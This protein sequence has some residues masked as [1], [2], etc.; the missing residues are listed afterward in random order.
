MRPGA[1][2]KA[3]LYSSVAIALVL[4]APR[5]MSAQ[6][7]ILDDGV[8]VDVAKEILKGHC[9]FSSDSENG[10]SRPFYWIYFALLYAAFGNHPAMFFLANAV[11][12]A[13]TAA[14]IAFLSH[15]ATGDAAQ[16]SLAGVLFVLSGPGIESYYTLSKGEPVQLLLVCASLVLA[17]RIVRLKGF[18]RAAHVAAMSLMLF[19]AYATKE[20]TIALIPI[21]FLWFVISLMRG[22]ASNR[23]TTTAASF[24]V[25][26]LIATLGFLAMRTMLGCAALYDGAYTYMYILDG[27]R[28][29]SSLSA[30]S[31][32]T[33][34]DFLYV[35]P[36][37]AGWVAVKA[38]GDKKT[39]EKLLAFALAW[40][41]SWMAV[42]M[43]WIYASEYYML[44]FAAGVTFVASLMAADVGRAMLRSRGIVKASLAGLLVASAAL[45]LPTLL[46]NAKN[47]QIQL[48]VNRV[49]AETL[50]Y[51]AD[52]TPFAGTVLLNTTVQ[53]RIF[54]VK[55][56]LSAI[57]DRPDIQV[58]VLPN[59]AGQDSAARLADY[60]VS[61]RI[62]NRPHL[63]V[64]M[65][66]LDPP[67][68]GTPWRT[69]NEGTHE[70]W[71][72]AASYAGSFSA[73]TFDLPNLM[74]SA[75]AE[76]LCQANEQVIDTSVFSYDVT[77][78]RRR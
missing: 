14:M 13:S 21:A 53:G 48:V 71:E 22:T 73:T 29:A 37:A 56:Y 18:V 63:A 16:A 2:K 8:S 72:A 4:M 76:N 61:Q 74:C 67:Q 55:L 25:A 59:T 43:P 17:T 78:E 11:L 75:F 32:W 45:F 36:L 31:L 77:I 57:E 27:A 60:V 66:M 69:S 34:R 30:W 39:H 65:F 70:S 3:V 58:R 49:D 5:I 47:A 51:I 28:T 50:E 62:S 6:F 68:D 35:A 38:L 24:G 12:L 7:G 52:S 33:A 44:P 40:S 54:E 15:R 41:A 10:R 20:T 46:T 26:V 1:L 23:S 19:L 64:R 9:P 42:F